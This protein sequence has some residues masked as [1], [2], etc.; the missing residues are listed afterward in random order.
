MKNKI[1]NKKYIVI[2]LICLTFVI[3]FCFGI[4]YFIKQKNFVLKINDEYIS[5]EEFLIYLDQQKSIFEQIGGVDIWQTDFD[6]IP[7][8]EV[9]KNN[10]INAIMFLKASVYKAKELKIKLTDEQI[11]QYKQD[12]LILKQNIE[13]TTGQIIPIKICEKFEKEKL[14]EQQV[15]DYITNG[16]VVDEKDFLKYFNNYV[17]ENNHTLYKI[18]LDYVFVKNNDTFDAQQKAQQ[19]LKKATPKTDFDIFKLDP[20]I[21]VEKNVTL[22]KDM[23][24]KTVEEKIHKLNENSISTVIQGTDGFYIF[25]INKISNPNMTEV[26]KFVK[27]EYIQ[28]K[29]DE[30]YKT[31]TNSWV[32]NLR[33]EKNNQILNSL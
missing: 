9:A 3:C 27:T 15:Y 13:K 25:K 26:E 8:N 7:A 19:I 11:Q 21:Q 12:A 16:F 29:K 5:K 24:E 4:T 1:K 20:F 14:I 23:F 6:G 18:N 30:L 2:F 10:A 31:Q 22:K 28:S 33:I 17:K 32:N